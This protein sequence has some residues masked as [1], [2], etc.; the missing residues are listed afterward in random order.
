MMRTLRRLCA[1]RT[2]VWLAVA[3]GTLG[4]CSSPDPTAI[5]GITRDADGLFRGIDLPGA[6]PDQVFDVA[7]RN[8]RTHFAGGTVE[9]NPK[10]RT[11]KTARDWSGTA[12]RIEFYL[13]VIPIT[14]GARASVYAPVYT[15]RDDLAKNPSGDPWK[16]WDQ[17]NFVENTI[18]L[19]LYDELFV[20][21][22][23]T[24]PEPA[25]EPST[26]SS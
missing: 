20:A 19:E 17:D 6:D 12:K 3:C 16:F 25:S 23:P 10:L 21:P 4:G 9:E 26:P 11:V 1:A 14:G 7:R 18:L 8:I 5:E 2:L 13:Q 24:A 22:M 15:L